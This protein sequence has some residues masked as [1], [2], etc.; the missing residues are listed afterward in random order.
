MT[1][2]LDEV[3]DYF[4]VV[5]EGHFREPYNDPVEEPI[6]E[7]VEITLRYNEDSFERPPTKNLVYAFTGFYNSTTNQKNHINCTEPQPQCTEVKIPRENPV[8]RMRVD[9]SYR[10]L[11]FRFKAEDKV[12]REIVDKFIKRL[13]SGE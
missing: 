2:T 13:K 5:T 9:R 1:F 10:E 7:N 4:P 3:E 8:I 6:Q 12:A 11:S